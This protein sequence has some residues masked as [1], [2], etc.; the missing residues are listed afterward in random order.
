MKSRE[1]TGT[2]N[3]TASL[4][5]RIPRS[6]IGKGLREVWLD[7][8]ITGIFKLVPGMAFIL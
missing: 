7:D 6:V 2:I 5:V 1:C 3:V 4:N 8:F